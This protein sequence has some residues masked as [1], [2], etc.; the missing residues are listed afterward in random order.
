MVLIVAAS[1]LIRDRVARTAVR[2]RI[3]T[4]SAMRDCL[5]DA[6]NQLIIESSGYATLVQRTPFH[7]LNSFRVPTNCFCHNTGR[8]VEHNL[9]LPGALR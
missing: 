1:W 7:P 4:C 3:S 2:D 8:R 5:T 6:G 9:E